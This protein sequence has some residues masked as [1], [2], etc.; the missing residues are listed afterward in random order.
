MVMQIRSPVLG[1]FGPILNLKWIPSGVQT[2]AYNVVIK[3][4]HQLG[5]GAV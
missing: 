3:T 4:I 2:T 1:V 5:G